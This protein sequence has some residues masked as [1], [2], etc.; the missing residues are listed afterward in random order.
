MYILYIW[1]ISHNLS[2]FMWQ[3]LS[4][5]YESMWR[6]NFLLGCIKEKITI[7]HIHTQAQ[8]F[9]TIMIDRTR[10][11]AAP[12]CQYGQFCSLGLLA[13]NG[14]E[15]QTHDLWM[16]RQC[17]WTCLFEAFWLLHCILSVAF[18]L[19]NLDLID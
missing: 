3:Q 8:I 13:T 7:Q 1:N 14:Y 12:S 6:L 11:Y 9:P 19:P 17:V 16:I 10:K 2:V 18:I 5:A 15:I 4:Q